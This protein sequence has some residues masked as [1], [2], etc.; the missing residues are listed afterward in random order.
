MINGGHTNANILKKELNNLLCS[1]NAYVYVELQKLAT[2]EIADCGTDYS[3]GVIN[4]Y[5]RNLLKNS[6]SLHT[7][8]NK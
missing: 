7:K 3:H 8:I 6:K 5:E 4:P 2:N 1:I